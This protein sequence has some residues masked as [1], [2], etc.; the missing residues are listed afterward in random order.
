MMKWLNVA[1]LTVFFSCT[2]VIYAQPDTSEVKIETIHVTG[3]VYMLVGS[4]GNLGVSVGPDGVFLIDDQYAPLSEKILAA[5][6]KIS[7]N[8]IRFVLNTHWH[9]DHTGGNEEFG[10]RAPIIS[11]INV[12]RRLISGGIL[13]LFGMEV[14][15]AGSG[16]LPLLTYKDSVTL[17]L[18]GEEIDVV[19]IPH[20]HTDGD[21]IV[22][23]NGS[24]V[25]HLGDLLFSGMFPFVDMDNG[26]SVKGL[27][28]N[29][30]RLLKSLPKDIKIIPGHGPLSSMQ[31]LKLYH[32]MLVDTTTLIRERIGEGQTE[33][34]V[35]TAGLPDR[36]N[37]W[38]GGFI[39]EENWIKTVYRAYSK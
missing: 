28:D 13:S 1:A 2:S 6:N 21:S 9:G 18:N 36:W 15:P 24:N 30:G 22:I 3:P 10:K 7:T 12:R 17:Y 19:H 11:H 16:S 34:D 20:A 33:E 31:D 4:G 23:F 8:Q 5:I 35:V 25:A 38:G 29:V 26:G 37:S 39:N 14:K 32:E 27:I